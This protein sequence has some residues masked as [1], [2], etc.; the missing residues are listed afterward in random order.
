MTNQ[1]TTASIGLVLRRLNDHELIIQ[2]GIQLPCLTASRR[3]GF[4]LT[5][6]RKAGTGRAERQNITST[7]LILSRRLALDT[8]ASRSG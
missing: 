4:P 8:V 1:C 7:V 5:N 6:S 3:Q 2:S